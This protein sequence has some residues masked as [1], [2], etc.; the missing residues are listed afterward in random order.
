MVVALAIASV[1]VYYQNG[2]DTEFQCCI[3][4]TKN[5]DSFKIHVRE[6]STSIDQNLRTFHLNQPA[7]SDETKMG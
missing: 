7:A 1:V 4:S 6:Y 5:C 3:F 2:T